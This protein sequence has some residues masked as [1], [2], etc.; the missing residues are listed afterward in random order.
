MKPSKRNIAN[1]KLKAERNQGR[2]PVQSK[3]GAKVRAELERLEN[4]KPK[5]LET[6]D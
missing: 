5:K 3:Y 1:A 2:K 6:S 4:A